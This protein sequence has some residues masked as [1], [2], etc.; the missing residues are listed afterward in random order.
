MRRLAVGG[1]VGAAAQASQPAPPVQGW[2][3]YV[4]HERDTLLRSTD[5]PKITE[6]SARPTVKMSLL[7]IHDARI[8]PS[9]FD[10][11]QLLGSKNLNTGVGWLIEPR[12]SSESA[13]LLMKS[14]S[15]P[16]PSKKAHTQVVDG[17]SQIV[18]CMS[19]G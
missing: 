13:D 10:F 3:I 9:V 8:A 19:V 11:Q 16:P 12:C 14:F 2:A 4:R 6:Y 17:G 7:K 1:A 15:E 18:S 5:L